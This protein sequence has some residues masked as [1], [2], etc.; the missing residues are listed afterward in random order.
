MTTT[1]EVPPE[2]GQYYDYVAALRRDGHIT[3]P[4]FETLLSLGR[5]LYTAGFSNGIDRAISAARDGQ[6]R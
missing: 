4:S 3:D 5:D 1:P 2:A 6:G